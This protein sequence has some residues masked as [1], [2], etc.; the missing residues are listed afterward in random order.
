MRFTSLSNASYGALY[1]PSYE[2]T[3]KIHENIYF[4]SYCGSQLAISL[5][6]LQSCHVRL[7][8]FVRQL[9]AAGLGR[10]GGLHCY[11]HEWRLFIGIIRRGGAAYSTVPTIHHAS[12]WG[13]KTQHMDVVRICYF[14]CALRTQISRTLISNDVL[15]AVFE[16]LL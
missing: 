15:Q 1:D 6:A 13:R 11:I 4:H 8:H 9:F 7:H 16:V 5:F 14:G 3:W 12:Y 2:L 10:R